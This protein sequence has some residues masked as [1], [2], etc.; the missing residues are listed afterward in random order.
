MNKATTSNSCLLFPFLFHVCMQMTSCDKY[1]L[2][3]NAY[4]SRLR[5]GWL[6]IDRR[7]DPQLEVLL[8]Q[9]LIILNFFA[10]FRVVTVPENNLRS[11]VCKEHEQVHVISIFEE[12]GSAKFKSER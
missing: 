11:K 6:C 1:Y 5:F 2:L 12:D 10:N 8:L 4:S 3:V 7:V 9:A